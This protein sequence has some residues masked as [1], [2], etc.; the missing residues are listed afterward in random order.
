[1]TDARTL[2]DEL[3]RLGNRAERVMAAASD[4]MDDD[5]VATAAALRTIAAWTLAPAPQDPRAHVHAAHVEARPFLTRL[6]WHAA[7]VEVPSVMTAGLFRWLTRR[8]GERNEPAPEAAPARYTYTPRKVLRRVLDHALD[9]LNQIDQWQTWRRDGVVPAP[10]DGWASSIVTLPED[11]LPLTAADLEAWLWRIDQVIRLLGQRA[12]GLSDAQLDWAPPDGGWPLRRVLH[13]VSRCERLYASA[14]EEAPP[15]TP[16]DRYREASRLLVEHAEQA[17][18]RGVDPSIVY[19]N[20][21]GVFYTPAQA[22]AEVV[23]MED[24]LMKAA[25]SAVM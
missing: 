1:M 9:H 16:L 4:A 15:A 25:P 11:L 10:T 22:I 21:Y 19:V 2:T 14:L 6:G 8:P 18:Q 5:A 23:E 7:D 17:A 24:A 3:P 13:H 12:A 20:L